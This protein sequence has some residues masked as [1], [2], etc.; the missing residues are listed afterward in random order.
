M[1]DFGEE[2][3]TLVMLWASFPRKFKNILRIFELVIQ[4]K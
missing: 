3:G 1:P 4:Q 2:L